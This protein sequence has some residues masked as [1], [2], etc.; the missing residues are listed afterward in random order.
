MF[1][2]K[3]A[4]SDLDDEYHILLEETRVERESL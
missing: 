3:H 1:N 4:V 2:E